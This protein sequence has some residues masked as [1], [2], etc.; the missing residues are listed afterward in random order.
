[1]TDLL[2][3]DFKRFFKDKLLIVIAI[4]SVVLGAIS[5]LLTGLLT[6]PFGDLLSILGM[7]FTAKH[8]FFSAFSYSNNMGLIAP[9]LI[10]IV[11]TKDFRYG[12]VRNKIIS[13]KSRKSIYLSMFTTCATMLFAVMLLSALIAMIVGLMFFPFQDTPFDAAA[14]QHFVLSLA[15]ELLFYLFIS[16]ILC[17]LCATAKNLGLVIILYVAIIML[18][19]IVSVSLQVALTILAYDQSKEIAL[20][21]ADFI[22]NINVFSYSTVIGSGTEYETSK[23]IYMLVTPTVFTSLLILLGIRTFNRKDL[24]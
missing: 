18:F 7:Q 15:L 16:A 9:I 6:K 11:I 19:D 3:V 23:L 4:L 20:K 17:Y 2:K 12:T 24:K 1:M 22:Q 14:L 21:I 8:Q 5:P 13:G 10:A